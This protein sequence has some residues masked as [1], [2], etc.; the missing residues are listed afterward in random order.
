MNL[1]EQGQLLRQDEF[2]V[3]EGRTSHKRV[4]RVFLFEHLVLFA[5]PRRI[6]VANGVER[7]V[8]ESKRCIKV[9]RLIAAL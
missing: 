7:E 3:Y 1:K 5:K 6:R 8:Y 9:S 4:R 2:V